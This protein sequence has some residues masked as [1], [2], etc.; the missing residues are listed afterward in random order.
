MLETF[1]PFINAVLMTMIQGCKHLDLSWLMLFVLEMWL[2]IYKCRSYKL[3]FL[4][5]NSN[6]EA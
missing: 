2:S 3:E 4:W 5:V 1:E 6:L